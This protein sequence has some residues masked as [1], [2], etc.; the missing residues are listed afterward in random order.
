MRYILNFLKTLL[1]SVAPTRTSERGS[2][3]AAGILTTKGTAKLRQW[4]VRIREEGSYGKL[5]T[6][7]QVVVWARDVDEADDAAKEIY[8]PLDSSVVLGPLGDK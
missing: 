6:P 5:L 8:G 3:G 7:K 2:I 1:S 4:V